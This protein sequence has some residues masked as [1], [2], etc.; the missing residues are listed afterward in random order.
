MGKIKI[1]DDKIIIKK[2]G[3]TEIWCKYYGDPYKYMVYNGIVFR[4]KEIN[5]EY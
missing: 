1:T 4:L 5:K 2:D 3:I